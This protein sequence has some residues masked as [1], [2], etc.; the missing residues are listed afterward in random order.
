MVEG[1]GVLVS[2]VEAEI[3][4]RDNDEEWNCKSC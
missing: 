3:E 2:T 1:R 4:A